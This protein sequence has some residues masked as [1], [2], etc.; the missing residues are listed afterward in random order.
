M[1]VKN[2][3]K[4]KMMRTRFGQSPRRHSRKG[5]KSCMSFLLLV[6]MI[7]ISFCL[8]GNVNILVGFAG[9]FTMVMA[10]YGIYQGVTGLRERDK[11]YIT[12]KVGI[13]VCSALFL[14]MCAIFI[15]GLV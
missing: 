14:G 9:L 8:K 15:R 12:C 5:M 7:W 4:R 3:Q 6:F 13:A 10:G 2:K 11:N 1:V